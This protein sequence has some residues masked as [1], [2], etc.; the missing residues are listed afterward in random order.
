MGSRKTNEWAGT[1]RVL[2]HPTRLMILE[3]LLKGVKC[4]ND[5]TELLELP[6]ANVSQHLMALREAGLV[7]CR[8]HGLFRC[9]YLPKPALIRGLFD[10]LGT[11]YRTAVPSRGKIVAASGQARRKTHA[12]RKVKK[13]GV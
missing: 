6:Q 10:V 12:R 8:R 1:L 13:R 2:S 5:M 3:E 7:Q 4:V 11:D 9:Y